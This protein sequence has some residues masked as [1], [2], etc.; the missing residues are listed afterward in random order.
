LAIGNTQN[1]Y[2]KRWVFG[3]LN[4][5][6]DVTSISTIPDEA[7]SLSEI[8]KLSNRLVFRTP[9]FFDF[10]R[11]LIYTQ[12]HYQIVRTSKSAA[13]IWKRLFENRLE[14]YLLNLE[15]Q[16]IPDQTT[17]WEKISELEVV[18]AAEFYLF[19][20]NALNDERIRSLIGEFTPTGTNGLG[21]IL[22]NYVKGLKI[23]AEEFKQLLKYLFRGGGKG[24]FRGR[25]KNTRR[26]KKIDLDSKT[27]Q[28][29]VTK[30][31]VEESSQED[32]LTVLNE[33]I[34]ME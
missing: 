6:S 21:V 26:Q 16:P 2:D 14:Q 10:E 13:R 25:E 18:N 23:D 31:L 12:S 9:F 33:L 3:F 15:V 5:V 1:L 22:K 29:S 32:I 30:R 7:I 11:Q 27:Q 28:I 20:P 8:Q 17:F 24:I 19:G 4:R 34:K